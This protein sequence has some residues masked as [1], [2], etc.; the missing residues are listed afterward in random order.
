[1]LIFCQFQ[2]ALTNGSFLFNYIYLI[3]KQKESVG[4]IFL[5]WG[6]RI[7]IKGVKRPS[8]VGWQLKTDRVPTTEV[9]SQTIFIVCCLLWANRNPTPGLNERKK[10]PFGFNWFSLGWGSRIWTYGC[11]SQSPMPYRLAIPH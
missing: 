9:G 4:S 10:N 5:G 1:M 11:W 2:T 7:C 8:I 6:S 3:K